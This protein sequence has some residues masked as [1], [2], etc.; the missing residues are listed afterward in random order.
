M[1]GYL[2]RYSN[3][4]PAGQSKQDFSLL[5]SVQTQS[6]IQS[7]PMVLSPGFTPGR[8]VKLTTHLCLVPNKE[9]WSYISIPRHIFMAQYLISKE[10]GNFYM[11]YSR[12]R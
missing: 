5:H 11:N 12:H 2:S 3:G 1:S 9:C 4:L 6:P 8:A 7:T 10:K